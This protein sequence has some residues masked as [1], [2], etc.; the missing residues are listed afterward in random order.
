VVAGDTTSAGQA[1]LDPVHVSSG[2]QTSSEPDRQTNDDGWKA[3]VGQSLLTPSQLSAMSQAPAATRQ[4]N[5]FGR[6]AHA[7]VEALTTSCPVV[8]LFVPVQPVPV[9]AVTVNV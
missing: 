2:S 5:P 7:P 3:S 1:A 4:T 6:D 8:V 9:D